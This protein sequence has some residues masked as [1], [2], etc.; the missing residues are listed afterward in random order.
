[1]THSFSLG[2]LPVGNGAPPIFFAEVGS[3][4]NG[5][6][7]LAMQLF[8]QIA[9]VRDRVED[10]P[11]ILKT[12]ILDDPEI[13]L[14]GELTETYV[15]KGGRV[16]RENYRELIERK[17]MPLDDYR[18][19]FAF[20]REQNLPTVVSVYDFKAADFSAEQ[21]AAGLKIASA[22]IVHLPL[23][24][25]VA[26]LKLP[27]VIDTGRA[28]LLEV[29]R[30]VETAREAGCRDIIVQHSPDGHPALPQAHNLRMLQSYEQA[31]GLPTGLSDHHVGVEMLY[32]AIALGASVLEKGLYFDAEE[33]DQDISHS[34]PIAD[35]ERV[36]RATMDCWEALGSTWRDREV[37]IKGNIGSSQRQGLVA[38][39]DL[40]SGDVIGT[41]HVRFAFPCLG[42]GAEHWPIVRG[43]SVRKDIAAGQPIGWGDV[44]AS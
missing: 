28:S 3:Y 7:S 32:M 5:D 27:M 38:K 19:L 8:R 22:N 1:M 40:K 43:W 31:F 13:C 25:Y 2:G 42:I 12:E 24:D 37:A 21:G 20:C 44:E 18:P 17:A 34:M 10:A 36:L 26:R 41:D 33:L 16:K 6:A 4:F 15:D 23:I 11:V 30:A 14:P 39:A 35:F 29:A 9:E